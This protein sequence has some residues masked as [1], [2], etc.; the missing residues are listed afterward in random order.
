MTD[1]AREEKTGTGLKKKPLYRLYGVHV[2]CWSREK[3]KRKLS[4]TRTV[5]EL[6]TKENKVTKRE[7]TTE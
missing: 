4:T 5:D 3:K 1:E 2:V 6:K 7:I